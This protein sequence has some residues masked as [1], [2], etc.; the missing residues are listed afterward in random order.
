M[1][2]STIVAL[3]VAIA[4]ALLVWL[5]VLSATRASR[6][7]RLNI[8]VDLARQAL[9]TAL[10]RRAVVAR[11]IAA[12]DPHDPLSPALTAAADHAEGADQAAREA[13]ENRL[14]SV[15]GQTDPERRVPALTAELADAQIRVAMARRFYNDAVRDARA[16]GGRRMVRWLHL[17]GHSVRPDFFEITERVTRD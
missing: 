10:D 9:H 11:A 16:L 2:T 14:S 15:L 3:A 12:A 6:M 4:V 1:T 8:R 13:A 17:A 7:D 5:V